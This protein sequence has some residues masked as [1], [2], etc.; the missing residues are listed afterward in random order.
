MTENSGNSEFKTCPYCGETIRAVAI[1]CKHCGEF[2]DGR[3]A[4]LTPAAA[5]AAQEPA[6]TPLKPPAPPESPEEANDSAPAAVEEYLFFPTYKRLI[7]PVA[8]FFIVL[9]TMAF[10]WKQTAVLYVLAIL[11]LY[12][13]LM[14]LQML[15]KIV[16][17]KYNVTARKV[18]LHEGFISRRETEVRIENIR[19]C[20]LKQNL[21]QRC[22]NFGDVMLGTSA[23]GD[24][25]IRLK[26]VDSP[27]EVMDLITRLQRK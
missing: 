9:I 13:L 4:P 14:A 27:K 3:G 1:K 20:W 15:F 21:W 6:L 18:R 11:L 10:Y 22:F 12:T 2:L 16:T 17:T 19:A 7:V 5:A 25:E 26:D 8:G 24:V 23:T